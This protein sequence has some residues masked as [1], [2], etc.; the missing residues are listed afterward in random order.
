MPLARLAP[1]AGL[2]LVVSPGSALRAQTSGG[3]VAT[4]EVHAS[5]GK[6][7]PGQRV[8]IDGTTDIDGGTRTVRI[9]VTG[10]ADRTSVLQATADSTGR[11]ATGYGGATE[12]GRYD[13]VAHSPG[14]R[15]SGT[16]SFTVA[17][18][19]SVT[20]DVADELDARLADAEQAVANL[21]DVVP[22]LP[23]S[24]PRD[25]LARRLAA[26][27]DQARELRQE[28]PAVR[29][30]LQSLGTM[31]ERAPASA[32]PVGTYVGQLEAWAETSRARRGSAPSLA[33]DNLYCE[34]LDRISEGLGFTSLLFNVLGK[35]IEIVNNM[36]YDK[37]VGD[38]LSSLANVSNPEAKF[39]IS[40]LLKYDVAAR[41]RGAAGGPIV[42]A[43]QLA[44]TIVGRVVDATHLVADKLFGAR[45]ERF[46]GTFS[47]RL[48]AE[49]LHDLGPWWRYREEIAG[50]LDLRYPKGARGRG[51]VAMTGEFLGVG[52]RYD[53]WE[54]AIRVLYPELAAYAT[55]W[56]VRR[57][58]I[59]TP[60]HPDMLK[61]G[62]VAFNLLPHSFHIP[63]TAEYEHD[64]ITVH[65]QPATSDL[66]E[67]ARVVYV[68]LSPLALSV[69]VNSA[70]FPYKDA[71]FILSHWAADGAITLPVESADG[72]LFVAAR[73]V[74][75][76]SGEQGAARGTYR[77]A[78]RVCNPQC[79]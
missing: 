4:V 62:K 37:L 45:C 48:D 68:F 21:A 43:N 58:P 36:L 5:P 26:V 52:T 35:P 54:D 8:T 12:P 59:G 29:E 31:I 71:Y 65:L 17:G 22:S 30:V 6:V 39:A 47:A 77:I 51:P 25:E 49:F 11:F 72:K 60:Y 15:A 56:H 16:A 1:L 18:A 74:E 76:H 3:Q 75:Q 13:V 24:P 78:I 9:E 28:L 69:I 14:G 67:H 33:A 42:R 19:G 10:A 55:T 53:I 40:G 70:D 20:G 34:Q 46:V 61:F 57:T 66:D 64:R 63:V 79:P 7:M 41:V 23:A 2:A 32:Q 44:E 50:V 38:A 27:R 73:R